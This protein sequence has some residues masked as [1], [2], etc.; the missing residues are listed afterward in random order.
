MNARVDFFYNNYAHFSEHVLAAVRAE[1]FGQDIGQNSWLTA[2][3]FDRFTGWLLLSAESNVL[4]VASGSGGPALYMAQKYGCRVTGVDMNPY[5]VSTAGRAAMNANIQQLVN[6][7]VAD[8]SST[9]P[10]VDKR[11][12]ALLCIDSMNHFPDRLQTLKE[13]RRVLKPGGRA[14]F[15]DPVAIT[16]PITNEEIAQRSSIGLFVFMTRAMTEELIVRAGF[17]ILSQQDVTENA[18]QVSRRWREARQRFREDLLR[19]EGEE[20]YE[21]VQKFL[22]AVHRLTSERR[23]S[24]I[25]YLV[26][27]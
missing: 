13:W 22:G 16:G 24:R 19:L 3:E 21:G 8:V 12:D 6:F 25:A 20:R 27:K 2:E 10:F 11:F 23:L 4:E 5:G 18:A 14:V 7:K 15:T 9:L 26:E 1:A 17:R